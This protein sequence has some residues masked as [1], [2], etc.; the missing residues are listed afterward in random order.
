MKNQKITDTLILHF[1]EAVELIDQPSVDT[2]RSRPWHE[3]DEI[4]NGCLDEVDA[5]GFKRLQEAARQADRHTIARPC[6]FASA[7]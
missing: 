4:A 3:I 6:P 5:G 7:G 1:V 2:G